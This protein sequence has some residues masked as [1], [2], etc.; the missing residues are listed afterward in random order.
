MT[1]SAKKKLIV[2]NAAVWAG[3]T[4][5]SFILPMVAASVSD[6]PAGFLRMM[7]HTGPLFLGLFVSTA[8]INKAIG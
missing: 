8:M 5:L 7:V 3:A 1:P 6:G 4:L 2:A